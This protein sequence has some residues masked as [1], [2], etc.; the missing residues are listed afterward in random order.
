MPIILILEEMFAGTTLI[1]E[2]F[3]YFLQHGHHI[4]LFTR[5]RIWCSVVF[6]IQILHHTR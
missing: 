1:P 5:A 2:I 6:P 3:L 4:F